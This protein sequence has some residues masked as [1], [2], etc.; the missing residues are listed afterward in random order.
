MSSEPKCHVCGT[1]WWVGCEH[2]ADYSHDVTL[3]RKGEKIYEGLIDLCAGHSIFAQENGGRLNLKQEA[4]DQANDLLA[5]D[6]ARK[7]K[8]SR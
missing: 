5:R 3:K 4:I 2:A 1:C 8:A 7:L 6:R